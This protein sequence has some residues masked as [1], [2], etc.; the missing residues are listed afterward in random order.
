MKRTTGE[1]IKRVEQALS[2]RRYKETIVIELV[3]SDED[4]QFV[5]Q[6]HPL[7]SYLTY[8]QALRESPPTRLGP[9]I[10]T[11]NIGAER[12]KRAEQT[13]KAG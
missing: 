9:R 12:R 8:E 6:N 2:F 10:V 5:K 13:A 4:H 1:R 11:I 3:G 7:E